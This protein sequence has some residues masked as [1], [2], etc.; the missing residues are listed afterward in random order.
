MRAALVGLTSLHTDDRLRHT[1][2]AR[3]KLDDISQ[4]HEVV[5]GGRLSGNVIVGLS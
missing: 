3:Y 5:E 4:A 1:I 2:G